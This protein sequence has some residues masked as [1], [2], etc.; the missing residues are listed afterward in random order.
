MQYVEKALQ[1]EIDQS[2]AIYELRY[3]KENGEYA[4][5]SIKVMIFFN[6]TL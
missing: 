3:Y 1:K 5:S 6:V 4:S 2:Q